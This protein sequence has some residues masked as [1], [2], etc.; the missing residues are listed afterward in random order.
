MIE[1][2]DDCEMVQIDASS[3]IS[4]TIR[5]DSMRKQAMEDEFVFLIRLINL[6]RKHCH[7]NLK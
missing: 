3:K 6:Y 5:I 1:L 7:I 4:Q 2:R